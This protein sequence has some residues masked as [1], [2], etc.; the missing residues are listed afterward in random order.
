M[1]PDTD[2]HP[3]TPTTA[4][5]KRMMD[6]KLHENKHKGH[7]AKLDWTL[8]FGLMVAEVEELKEELDQPDHDAVA[9]AREAADVANFAMMIADNARQIAKDL[10]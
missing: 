3:W 4:W 2:I 5:F 10:K 6:T 9:I 8:L 1:K 7:W